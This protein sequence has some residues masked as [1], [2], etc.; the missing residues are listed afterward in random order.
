LYKDN[1]ELG[2][3]YREHGKGLYKAFY[4]QDGFLFKDKRL[5]IPYGSVRELILSKSHGGGLMGHFGVEKTL[6]MV[7]EHFFWPHLKK[8]VERF[9]ARC[10][11]CNKAKSRSHPHGLY[12]PLPIPN[13]PWVDV[14]MDFVLGLPKIK[15]KDSI[16]VVVDRFSKMAHFIPCDKTNDATQTAEL[17]FKEVVRLHGI[18]RTIVSDHDTKFLS[19]FWRTLWR[20]LGTKL[21]F[22]TT[23]HP[24][25]DGQTEVVNRTLSTLLRVTLGKNMSTW[26]D[27]IPFIEFAYNRAVHSGTKLS[28]F[29]I[30]YGI[31]P[32]SPLDLVPLPEKEQVCQ[33]GL[34]RGEI[35]KKIHEKPKANLEKKA[36]ENKRKADR[37]RKEMLFELGDWV[38]LHMRPERFPTQRA[39]KLAPRGDGPFKILEKIT[40][41]AYR[42][43][44]PSEVR[45]SHTF[46]VAELSAY[47]P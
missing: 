14:S 4:L 17:F 45:I 31:N 27:C 11:V 3:C 25:T 37:G 26:L 1:P 22:S 24:Q 2:E 6:A 30:V 13:A 23:C 21:L 38:W 36:A 33:D 29:E 18:P 15:H 35:I 9:C 19:H 43:E 20:K 41:N 47:D 42:L 12:L 7:I 34:R 28:P 8:D 16:F 39:S 44:L 40:D 46:N 10:I 32:L 5:C